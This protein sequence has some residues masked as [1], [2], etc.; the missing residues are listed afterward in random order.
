MSLSFGQ[1]TLAGS[2]AWRPPSF[3]AALPRITEFTGTTCRG[4]AARLNMREPYRTQFAELLKEGAA[5]QDIHD[6]PD[7]SGYAVIHRSSDKFVQ[8]E[9]ARVDHHRR[10]ACWLLEEYVGRVERILD[11]GCGTGGFSVALA[12]SPELRPMEVVGI[13]ASRLAVEAAQ[14]RA[15]GYD[16]PS[17]LVSFLGC[18][19]GKRLPF[20]DNCFDLTVCSSVIEFVTSKRARAELIMEL[21]RVTRPRG[22]VFIST[23]NP[24][25]LYEYHSRKFLGDYFHRSGFP[26][27]SCPWEFSRMFS[28]WQEIPVTKYHRKKL[29]ERLGAPLPIP[30]KV[31]KAISWIAPWQNRLFHKHR[32]SKMAPLQ[33]SIQAGVRASAGGRIAPGPRTGSEAYGDASQCG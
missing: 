24:L 29:V 33:R 3:G 12:S 21:G 8:R 31:V 13:D 10:N 27:A 14:V 15:R 5:V 9:L 25:R 11:V 17:T 6:S 1:E 18:S 30:E 28:G 16:L 4:I 22:Y 19:P 26:W 20:K 23:P 32:A 7:A 2:P